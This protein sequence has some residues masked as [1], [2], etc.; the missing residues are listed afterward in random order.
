MH[1]RNLFI[2]PT[3][4]W[5]RDERSKGE[6][7]PSNFPHAEDYG[8]FYEIINKGHAAIIPEDL[9]ICEINPKG[10]SLYFRQEQLKSRMQVV[11]QYGKNRL[12]SL[13]G[14]LKLW[15]LLLIPYKW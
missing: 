1:F 13:I 14:V 2:H 10:L 6:I 7:Y 3:V 15:V 11:R 9:V 8:F 4:M 12:Y 5:R